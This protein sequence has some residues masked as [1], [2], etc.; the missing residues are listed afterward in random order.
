MKTRTKYTAII[1]AALLH[2]ITAY[3][4]QMPFDSI[5]K[6][7]GNKSTAELRSLASG[8]ISRMQTDSALT[9][10]TMEPCATATIR[11]GTKRKTAPYP[12]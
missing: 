3:G 7:F 11:P 2:C 12:P 4:G 6:A 1:V 9:L 10:Y 5:S 8:C